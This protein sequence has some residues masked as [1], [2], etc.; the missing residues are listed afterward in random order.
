MRDLLKVLSLGLGLLCGIECSAQTISGQ[1]D[2]YDYVDL[3]LPSGTMWA[4]YNVGATKPTEQGDLFAWGETKPKEN[5]DWSTYKYA[6][7]IWH[8]GKNKRKLELDSLTKYNS[9]KDYPGTI[10][11]LSVL[12]PEDDAATVN[13]GNA[14]RMPT[15]AEQNELRKGCKWEWTKNYNGSGIA[16]RV[17]TSKAN[18]NTIFLPAAGSR[19]GTELDHP[20]CLGTYWS[21]SLYEY[22]SDSAYCL[23]FTALLGINGATHHRSDSQSVRAVVK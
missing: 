1:I 20:C 18:G 7:A 17:G 11:R 12:L 21:S 14:W 2:G 8:E 9:G 15:K 19:I 23:D 13:W 4:T 3:G 6:K 5:S 16:G 10:D 22:S